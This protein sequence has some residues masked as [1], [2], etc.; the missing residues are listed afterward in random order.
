MRN[1][2]LCRSAVKFVSYLVKVVP[3]L[4]SYFSSG[5]FVNYFTLAKSCSSVS[6]VNEAIKT[7]DVS[8][9]KIHNDN[10]IAVWLDGVGFVALI[11]GI[12]WKAYKGF[13]PDESLFDEER[14]MTDLSKA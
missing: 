12:A 14:E 11:L 9:P 5:S 1:L 10:L 7:L 8:A 13:K 2:S 3:L 4:L 6:S